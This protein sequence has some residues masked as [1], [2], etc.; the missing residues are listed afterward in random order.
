VW[1]LFS[2]GLVLAII[3]T[4][5]RYHLHTSDPWWMMLVKW[6]RRHRAEKDVLE[7]PAE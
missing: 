7:A 4:P 6:R 3:K 5:L 2:I 1:C